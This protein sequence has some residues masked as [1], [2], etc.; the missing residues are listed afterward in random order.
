MLQY[1]IFTFIYVG[2]RAP[3]PYNLV[4]A[5][6]HIGGVGGGHYVTYGQNDVNR[7]WYL[8]D[9]DIVRRVTQEQVRSLQ[10][11]MLIY[12]LGELCFQVCFACLEMK[13]N[14]NLLFI[15]STQ[16]SL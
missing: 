13:I 4:S 16:L 15:V 2:T 7:Q 9:D 14:S 3:G 12:R 11:Y 8:F 10:S 1:F 6:C 5:V